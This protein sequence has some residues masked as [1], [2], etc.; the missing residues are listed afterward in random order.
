MKGEIVELRPATMD[1][2]RPIFEWLACSDITS[3]AMGPPLYPESVPCTWEE[4]CAGYKTHY[5]DGSVPRLGRCF[6]ILADGEAVGQVNYNDIPDL[7]TAV[8]LDIWL[9]ARKYCGKGYGPDA[10]EVLIEYLYR[11]FGVTEFFLQ[12]SAR[13]PRAIRAYEKAG[14]Q[15]V[16]LPLEEAEVRYSPKDY[17]D[18]VY[19]VKKRFDDTKGTQTDDPE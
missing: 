17:S 5:F 13:N 11:E 14:F 1:D 12:P 2:R 9:R 10:L 19:L 16:D 3:A 15:R 7:E 8:E 4:F 18:S 6:V